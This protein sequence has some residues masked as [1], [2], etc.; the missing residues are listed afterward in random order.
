MGATHVAFTLADARDQILARAASA[1]PATAAP[2]TA[3]ADDQ[4]LSEHL[5]RAGQRADWAVRAVG[6]LGL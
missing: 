6:P 5:A 1:I 4:D 2:R 3:N